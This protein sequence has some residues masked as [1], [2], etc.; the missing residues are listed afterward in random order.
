[1]S[2]SEWGAE[3]A[4]ATEPSAAVAAKA[5]ANDKEGMSAQALKEAKPPLSDV[6]PSSAG[7]KASTARNFRW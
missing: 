1:M 7:L 6:S 3:T 2:P 5:K 4:L